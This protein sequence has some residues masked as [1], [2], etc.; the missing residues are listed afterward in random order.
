MTGSPRSKSVRVVSTITWLLCA[1][2]ATIVARP[3]AFDYIDSAFLSAVRRGDP[4]EVE[5][6]LALG[7]DPNG[8][9]DG[10]SRPMQVRP[11]GEAAQRGYSAVVAIL[12]RH[13]ADVNLHPNYESPAL[14]LAA[15]TGHL[16]EVR[17]LLDRGADTTAVDMDGNTAL[18]LGAFHPDVVELLVARGAPVDSANHVGLTALSRAA[19]NLSVRST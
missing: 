18:I 1:V 12:I 9:R 11:L 4:R 17:M 6:Y 5:R 3:Y 13:G 15:E 19:A 7:A 2:T 14:G 10:V 8:I 16:D